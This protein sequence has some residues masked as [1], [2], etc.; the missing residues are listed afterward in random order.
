MYR[1]L[2]LQQQQH[3]RI[4]PDRIVSMMMLVEGGAETLTLQS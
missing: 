3:P 1:M 4:T 2:S